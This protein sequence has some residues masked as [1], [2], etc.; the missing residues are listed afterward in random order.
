MPIIRE[1]QEQDW[2]RIK[3][4]FEEGIATGNATFATSAPESYDA[5][6]SKSVDGC[7]LVAE[8]DGR[9]V[10]WCKLW[11]TSDHCYYAGVGEVSI[12]V[13]AEHRGQGVGGA[14]MP[15]LIRASEERGF[16]TLM[17]RIF[18]ENEA[19]VRLHIRNGFRI[20]G[21]HERLGQMNNVWRDVLLLERRSETVGVD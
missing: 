11:P 3:T 17:S 16:W 10:G 6:R 18:P 19:S 15:A 12:Y 7:S 4:I 13:D 20:V 5:W 2:P 9:V 14:L 21:T 1:A 8:Q